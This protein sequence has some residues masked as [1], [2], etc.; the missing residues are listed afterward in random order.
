MEISFERDNYYLL[1]IILKVTRINV[2]HHMEI[3]K[4]KSLIFAFRRLSVVI[5][6]ASASA[7]E[8][9]II[10]W[11]PEGKEIFTPKEFPLQLYMKKTSPP[12]NSYESPLTIRNKFLFIFRSVGICNRQAHVTLCGRLSFQS[13]SNS[14]RSGKTIGWWEQLFSFIM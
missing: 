5:L 1:Q 10:N 12:N 9:K 13:W 6:Q 8:G 11:W 4:R 3:P 14:S 7:T 2:P